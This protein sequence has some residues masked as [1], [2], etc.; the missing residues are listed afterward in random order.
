MHFVDLCFYLLR[1]LVPESDKKVFKTKLRQNL[2][3][4]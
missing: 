3:Q 2:A 4:F 1:V